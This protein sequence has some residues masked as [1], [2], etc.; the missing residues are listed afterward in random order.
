M[1]VPQ[2]QVLGSRQANSFIRRHS[3]HCYL[4]PG[5]A[6]Y[7]RDQQANRTGAEHHSKIARPYTA[8]L[9]DG[10]GCNRQRLDQRSLLKR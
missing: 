7:L 5:R 9:Q 3:R 2:L 4:G 8:P 1:I 6:S 10:V